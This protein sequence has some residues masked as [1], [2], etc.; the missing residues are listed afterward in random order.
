[1]FLCRSSELPPQLASA[2]TTLAGR[3][4]WQ[5]AAIKEWAMTTAQTND[6]PLP[7]PYDTSL[8]RQYLDLIKD[9]I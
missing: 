7:V 8:I 1:M 4:T 2:T 9:H 3:A 6:H 5:R